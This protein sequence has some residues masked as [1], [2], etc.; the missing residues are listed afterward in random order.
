MYVPL[1]SP[2]IHGFFCMV[3]RR[4]SFRSSSSSTY[5]PRVQRHRVHHR[6]YKSR[7]PRPP[8]RPRPR[9]PSRRYSRHNWPSVP[10]P[11]PQRRYANPW[12]VLVRGRRRV[13]GHRPQWRGPHSDW[14]HHRP[15]N[16]SSS[17]RHG[18]RPGRHCHAVVVVAGWMVLLEEEE[19]EQEEPS[20]PVVVVVVAVVV[21][22]KMEV[23]AQSGHVPWLLGD[24]WMILSWLWDFLKQPQIVKPRVVRDNGPVA[25][26]PMDWCHFGDWDCWETATRTG[27]RTRRR[28]FFDTDVDCCCCGWSWTIAVSRVRNRHLPNRR[29]WRLYT[30]YCLH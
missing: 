1:L 25:S 26:V 22:G 16:W 12:V 28:H 7:P 24:W 30:N 17:S 11:W 19:E 10:L 29:A 2:C 15:Q 20:S 13:A 9:V 5:V 27:A 4:V 6:G 8:M 18:R 23:E 21:V 3:S 14:N